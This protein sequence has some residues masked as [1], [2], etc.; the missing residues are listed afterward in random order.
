[1]KTYFT[2]IDQIVLALC[3]LFTF[4]NMYRMVRRATVPI[5]K[6]PAYF[7]RYV[8]GFRPS[9]RDQLPRNGAGRGRQ[10]RL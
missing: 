2:Y 7:L 3:F 5:R 8:S 6:V 9:V 10:V 1:M 4:I